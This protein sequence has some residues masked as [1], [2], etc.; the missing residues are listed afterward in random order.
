MG[1]FPRAELANER[2]ALFAGIPMSLTIASGRSS[3]A[4][5]IA[6]QLRFEISPHQRVMRS[7]EIR[8]IS[9]A[10]YRTAVVET[11]WS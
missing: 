3:S 7:P 11:S 5:T 6:S 1:V 2:I 10:P 8:A 9:N 4:A